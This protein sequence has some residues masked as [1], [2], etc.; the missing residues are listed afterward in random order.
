MIRRHTK[1]TR[2]PRQAS[3]TMKPAEWR[4]SGQQEPATGS[5][6]R[7]ASIRSWDITN[8]SSIASSSTRRENGRP[9]PAACPAL[10]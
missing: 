8:A 1:P 7:P 6:Y 10:G 3:L 4:A 9:R 5:S 2:P